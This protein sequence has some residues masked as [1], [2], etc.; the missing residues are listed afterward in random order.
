MLR[1][2]RRLLSDL[3]KRSEAERRMFGGCLNVRRGAEQRTTG[4]TLIMR[5][6]RRRDGDGRRRRS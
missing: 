5:W 1:E 3:R 2:G 6:R 4:S